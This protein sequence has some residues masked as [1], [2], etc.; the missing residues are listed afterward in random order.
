MDTGGI[1]GVC[2]D[3]TER[4]G[5]QEEAAEKSAILEATMNNTDEG[6]LMADG[7]M[8]VAAYNRRFMEMMDLPEDL[9]DG[10]RSVEKFIRIRIARGD[11]ED[12]DPAEI[13]EQIMT[14]LRNVE[15]GGGSYITEMRS[16]SQPHIELRLNRIEGGGF[17]SSYIDIRSQAGRTGAAR[18][19]RS[20]RGGEQGQGLFPRDHEP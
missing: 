7:D 5:L 20:S 17:V 2:N 13:E 15:V 16:P 14:R 19:T 10:D 12:G 3:I 11:H 4:V 1:V 9:F 6:I 18:R 8:K